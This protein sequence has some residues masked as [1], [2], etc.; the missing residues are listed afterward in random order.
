MYYSHFVEQESEPQTD[1]NPPLTLKLS[2]LKYK[3]SHIQFHQI[4][5]EKKVRGK[6]LQRKII[7]ILEIGLSTLFF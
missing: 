6:T 2:D 3:A 1:W 4:S 5:P 7:T